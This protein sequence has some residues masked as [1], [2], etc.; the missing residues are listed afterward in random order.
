[1][2]SWHVRKARAA[3]RF[4][5]ALVLAGFIPIL[6]LAGL[7]LLGDAVGLP[8]RLQGSLAFSAAALAVMSFGAAIA[9]RQRAVLEAARRDARDRERR[10][11]Q[12]GDGDRLE[13]FIGGAIPLPPDFGPR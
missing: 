1:M 7:S 10:V 3:W 4:G 8:L 2:T 9:R 11:R 13:P 5:F 12:Y 6:L